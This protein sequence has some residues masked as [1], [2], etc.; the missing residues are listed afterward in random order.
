MKPNFDIATEM[1]QILHSED[2]SIV[3][4]NKIIKAMNALNEAASC[5]EFVSDIKTSETIENLLTKISE[6]ISK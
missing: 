5:S 1:N 3:N 6:E 2:E 4:Y